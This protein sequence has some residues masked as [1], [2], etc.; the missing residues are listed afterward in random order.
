MNADFTE[1]VT[2]TSTTPEPSVKRLRKGAVREDGKIFWGYN[3]KSK[4]GEYWL[5]P[6][7]FEAMDSKNKENCASFYARNAATQKAAARDRYRANREAK[8]AYQATYYRKNLSY[9]RS[10]IQG[11]NVK[12]YRRLR[13]H[14]NAYERTRRATDPLFALKGRLRNRVSGALKRKGF[15]KNTKT[16]IMLGCTYEDFKAYIE[17]KFLPGMSWANFSDCHIDHIVPLDAADTEAEVYTL[18]HYTNLRPMWG[19]EN[20]S[21]SSKLPEEHELPDNLHTKV[22]EIYLTAK[23]RSA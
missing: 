19:R 20:Q 8:L 12:N 18:N 3:P 9:I 21:K 23:A 14:K 22:K 6:N 13:N 11:Y 15:R 17:S 16:A 5:A 1:A 2:P 7:K 4:G 10:Y